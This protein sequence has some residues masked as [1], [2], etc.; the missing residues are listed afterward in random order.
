MLVEKTVTAVQKYKV[1]QVMI[2]GGVAANQKL[3]RKL[4]DTI[5]K[6]QTKIKL[7]VPPPSLCTDNGAMIAATAFFTNPTKDPLKIEAN[8]NLSLESS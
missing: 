5:T 7:H 6:L 3:V 8:P 1:E 2:A 4:Q